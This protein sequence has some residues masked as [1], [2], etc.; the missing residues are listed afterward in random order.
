M[1]AFLSG[2]NHVSEGGGPRQLQ[3]RGLVALVGSTG[4]QDV[5]V[6]E[7]VEDRVRIDAVGVRSREVVTVAA[8][9]RVA[10]RPRVGEGSV[11][12]AAE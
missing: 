9:S 6:H 8:D 1:R 3:A 10:V 7:A 11:A 5:G 4:P 2:T 12:H